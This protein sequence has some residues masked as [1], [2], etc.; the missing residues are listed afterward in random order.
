MSEITVDKG[1]PIPDRQR[2]GGKY[3]WG[4]LDVGDS[5]FVE[6]DAKRVKALQGAV[7]NVGRRLGRTFTTRR[8]DNGVRIWRTA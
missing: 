7:S 4:T 5:F 2:G 6:G 8:L 1:I 3:P